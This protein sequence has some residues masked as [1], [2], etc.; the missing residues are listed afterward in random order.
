LNV[1]DAFDECIIYINDFR[2]V[3]CYFY[4]ILFQNIY[5]D[6]IHRLKAFST[7]VRIRSVKGKIR[8]KIRI[9]SEKIDKKKFI[10]IENNLNHFRMRE[11]FL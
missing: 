9:K 1:L 3:V 2:M 10:K 4:F 7:N 6:K 8:I 11:D 5:T